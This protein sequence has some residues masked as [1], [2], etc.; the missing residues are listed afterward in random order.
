MSR[1]QDLQQF[2]LKHREKLNPEE[3]GFSTHHRRVKGLR[4]EEVAQLAAVSVSWYT[5]LEQGRDISISPAALKRIG[6]VLR[7]TPDEQEYL[8]AIVF[9]GN[10]SPIK[11]EFLREDVVAMVNALDPHPAFL[12]SENMDILYWNKA[13]EHKIFNWGILPEKDRNSLKLMFLN[14]EYR[15]RIPDWEKAAKQTIASFRSYYAISKNK[16]SFELVI[17]DLLLRSED[18]KSMWGDYEVRKTSYGEKEI[19]DNDGIIR[20]YSYT[21]FAPENMFGI[22]LIFYL[23]KKS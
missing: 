8:S 3:Y 4:R 10:H 11:S 22:F 14:K 21:A 9:G 17:D 6:S 16:A 12:R 2:L 19:I 18:F 5:W 15:K 23:E 7:L 20:Q 13:T 1:N